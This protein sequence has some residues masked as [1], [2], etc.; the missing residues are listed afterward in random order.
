MLERQGVDPAEHSERL[1]V[2]ARA[3]G[4]LDEL[5]QARRDAGAELDDVGSRGQRVVDRQQRAV[6]S[7]RRRDRVQIRN[8]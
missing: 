7:R 5:D 1:K 6:A 4:R 2:Y 3:A 8:M